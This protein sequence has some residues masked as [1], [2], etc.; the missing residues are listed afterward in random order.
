MRRRPERDSTAS[1]PRAPAGVARGSAG[2]RLVPPRLRVAVLV[3]ALVGAVMPAL[4]ADALPPVRTQ[5]LLRWTSG[6]IGLDESKA[7]R[8]EMGKWPVS[9]MFTQRSGGRAAYASD[10]HVVVTDTAGNS[11]I[12]ATADGPFMLIDLPPGQYQLSATL[13][14]REQIRALDVQAG[15]PIKLNL[16]W[17]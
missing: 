11:L 16:D 5:G 10:T 12:D 17:Q 9:L 4:A 3:C 14:G 8:A 2:S 6:G 1:L 15:K 7:M 13:D